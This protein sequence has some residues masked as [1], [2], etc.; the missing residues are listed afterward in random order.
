M[1]G[2]GQMSRSPNNHMTI[3]RHVDDGTTICPG[4]NLTY[5]LGSPTFQNASTLWVLY[6]N[7]VIT[8]KI[9]W[10]VGIYPLNHM[11]KF[12]KSLQLYGWITLKPICYSYDHH[13]FTTPAKSQSK[14]EIE[15]KWLAAIGRGLTVVRMI[16]GEKK[17]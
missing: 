8:C 4:W 13:L 14:G 2:S 17:V 6:K 5:L 9:R 1:F 16:G 12:I 3:W 10:T 7:N 11:F 15:L